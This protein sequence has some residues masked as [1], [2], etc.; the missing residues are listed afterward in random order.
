MV[1][2]TAATAR[3]R[4]GH[5]ATLMA[6]G[7]PRLSAE[8]RGRL[9]GVDLSDPNLWAELRAEKLSRA[10]KSAVDLLRSRAREAFD[11]GDYARATSLYEQLAGHFTRSDTKRFEIASRRAKSS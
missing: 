8:W 10:M 3:G 9:Q 4:F 5:R 7:A 2:A 11:A 1:P 6:L